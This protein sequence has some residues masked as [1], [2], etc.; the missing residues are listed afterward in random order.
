MCWLVGCSL[1]VIGR[2]WLVADTSCWLVVVRCSSLVVGCSL[3][4]CVFVVGNRLLL[5][6]CLL[7]VVGGCVLFVVG[8]LLCVVR[9]RLPGV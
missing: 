4:D 5:V 7:F 9:C 8:G 6:V 1:L 3:L 2:W